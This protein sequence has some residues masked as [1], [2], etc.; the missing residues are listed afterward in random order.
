MKSDSWILFKVIP[1]KEKSNFEAGMEALEKDV[2]KT[3]NSEKEV[4]ELSGPAE[5]R[6][7]D[8]RRVKAGEHVTYAPCLTSQIR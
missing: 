6:T 3:S 8:L 1:L 2:Y 4:E 5:I 7:Q